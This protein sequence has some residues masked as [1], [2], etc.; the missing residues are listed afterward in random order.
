M[1]AAQAY[2]MQP[3]KAGRAPS[4]DTLYQRIRTAVP[5]YRDDRPLNHLLA[6]VREILQTTHAGIRADAS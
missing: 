6:S 1:S 2:D 4:T 3:D 5:C